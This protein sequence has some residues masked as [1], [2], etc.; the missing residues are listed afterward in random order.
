MKVLKAGR[1]C[2]AKLAHDAVHGRR[3]NAA[4][5]MLVRQA[6]YESPVDRFY[7]WP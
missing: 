7:F 2:P 5:R 6:S 3:S 4:V 1:L